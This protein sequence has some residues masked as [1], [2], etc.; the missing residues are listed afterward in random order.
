[1]N[2]ELTDAQK[3]ARTQ[4]SELCRDVITPKAACIDRGTAGEIQE[5]IRNNIKSLATA[6]YFGMG[7]A[8]EHGGTDGDIITEILTGEELARSCPST[9]LAADVS[10]RLVGMTLDRFG[11]EQQKAAYLPGIIRGD[12]LGSCAIATKAGIT[13]ELKGTLWKL[14]GTAPMM[15][16][17]P[18]AD[19]MLIIAATDVDDERTTTAF[20][21]DTATGSVTVGSPRET[22]GMRGL[23]MADVTFDGSEVSADAVVGTIGSGDTVAA[24]LHRLQ[25]RAIAIAALGISVAAMEEGRAYFKHDGGP[26]LSQMKSFKFADMMVLTDLS[27]LLLYQAAWAEENDH[28]ETAVLA[29]CANVFAR[30]AV[31]QITDSVLDLEGADGYAKGSLAERLCRDGRFCET[32]GSTSEHMK[33]GIAADILKQYT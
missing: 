24:L 22:L 8:G 1:M 3:A 6:G 15:G 30:D 5:L 23:L 10:A 2:Y 14:N 20:M 28:H 27:R 17:I 4:I 32:Y 11:T 7:Y 25:C 21:V 16:N 18:G 31:R 26:S 13:A 33:N 9:Y 19:V 12:I 29:S